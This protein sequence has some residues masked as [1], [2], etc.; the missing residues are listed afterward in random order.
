MRQGLLPIN[1]AA[2]AKGFGDRLNALQPLLDDTRPVVR[3]FASETMQ[4]VRAL[5]APL[6][7]WAEA[8]EQP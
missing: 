7:E 5:M 1:D 4:S 6:K 2:D 8:I 3:Q